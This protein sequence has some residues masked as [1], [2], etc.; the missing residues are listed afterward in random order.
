MSQKQQTAIS[1]NEAS[2]PYQVFLY[3]KQLSL[4]KKKSLELSKAKLYLSE[5]LVNHTKANIT[6]L[7]TEEISF[8]GRGVIFSN[9]LRKWIEGV[10]RLSFQQKMQKLLKIVTNSK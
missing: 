4:R 2:V 9:K 7:K 8:L 6:S 1:K 3:R 10:E 5:S